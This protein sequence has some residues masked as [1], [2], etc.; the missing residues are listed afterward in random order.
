MA[1]RYENSKEI[2]GGH[3][4][5][6]PGSWQVKLKRDGGSDRATG[7][8]KRPS[9]ARPMLDRRHVF[10]RGCRFPV[11]F[12]SPHLR[13]A[14]AHLVPR[15]PH[16]PIPRPRDRSRARF[17]QPRTILVL[18]LELIS[19]PS[20]RNP[21]VHRKHR[22]TLHRSARPSP[23]R[24]SRAAAAV[25]PSLTGQPHRGARG[26]RGEKEVIISAARCGAR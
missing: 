3:S 18:R 20:R 7:L 22:R 25:C 11:V 14:A 17:Q 15:P 1:E 4:M 9:N 21:S 16:D 13:P 10:R 2:I 26:Q 19:A 24:I 12:N 23:D 6:S 8:A 5:V